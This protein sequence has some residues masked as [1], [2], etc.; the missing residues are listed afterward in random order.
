MKNNSELIYIDMDFNI[1]ILLEDMKK[2]KIVIRIRDFKGRLYCL[3]WFIFIGDL[4][5]GMYNEFFI[6]GKVICFNFDGKFI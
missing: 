5:V 2:I 1:R 4:L 3:Y 6:I